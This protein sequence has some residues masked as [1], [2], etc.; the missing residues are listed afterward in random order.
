M[1][2]IIALAILIG[3]AGFAVPQSPRPASQSAAKERRVRQNAQTD[4]PAEIQRARGALENAKNEL[5]HAGDEWG[6]HRVAALRHVNQAL[7]EI[8]QAMAYAR[9]HKLVK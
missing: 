4:V 1:R 5:E 8:H 3:M 6:G 2:K 9:A 7:A